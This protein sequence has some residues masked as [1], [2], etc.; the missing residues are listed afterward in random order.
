MDKERIM[1]GFKTDTEHVLST[2]AKP[3]QAR[4]EA[5]A[6]SEAIKAKGTHRRARTSRGLNPKGITK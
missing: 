1:P 6:R 2:P 3:T 5:L 4:L